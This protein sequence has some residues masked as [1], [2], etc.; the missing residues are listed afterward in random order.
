MGRFKH[1]KRMQPN[2]MTFIDTREEPLYSNYVEWCEL[3]NLKPKK[4]TTE[5]FKKWQA[6]EVE[7][8]KEDFIENISWS[9]LDKPL[10]ITGELGLWDG[11]HEIKPLLVRSI[12]YGER[13]RSDGTLCYSMP[14]L[15]V[16]IE[17]CI[18]GADDYRVSWYDKGIHIETWHHDGCNCFEIHKLNINGYRAVEAADRNMYEPEPQNWW[19]GKI[20]LKDIDF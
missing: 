1:G 5:H 12:G 4:D 2:K 19:Y 17:M 6:R 13:K 11:K 20:L 15:R 9:K 3:N 16:A 14:A 7:A 10:V 8:W 18:E